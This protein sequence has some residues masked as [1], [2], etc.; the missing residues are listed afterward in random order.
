[1]NVALLSYALCVITAI[2]CAFLLTRGYQHGGSR[3]LFWSA[4]CFWGLT[5]TNVLGFVD[6]IL[7]GQ[8][9]YACR[10]ATG[11]LSVGVMLFGMV[12]ELR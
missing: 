1:M 9:L 3:L 6:I 8:T 4:L 11:S 12:W 2:A 7:V 10:L 5:L